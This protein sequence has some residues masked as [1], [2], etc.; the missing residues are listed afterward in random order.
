MYTFSSRWSFTV[1]F[2]FSSIFLSQFNGYF[3]SRKMEISRG[4]KSVFTSIVDISQLERCSKCNGE[5]IEIYI[6]SWR[7]SVTHGQPLFF[8]V[9]IRMNHSKSI[10]STSLVGSFTQCKHSPTSGFQIFIQK[11]YLLINFL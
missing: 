4:L 7:F 5:E 9:R 1:S 8:T 11:W 2:K 6:P 3:R 10:L